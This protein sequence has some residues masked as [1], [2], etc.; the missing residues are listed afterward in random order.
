MAVTVRTTLLQIRDGA[1]LYLRGAARGQVAG[2][3][4]TIALTLPVEQRA[5]LNSDIYNTVC[6]VVHENDIVMADWGY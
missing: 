5:S 4:S 6:P 3:S 2:G 1:M